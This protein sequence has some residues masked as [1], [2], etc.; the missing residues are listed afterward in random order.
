MMRILLRL[1]PLLAALM[2]ALTLPPA[3]LAGK[4]PE[5]GG[6]GSF[7]RSQILL[8]RLKSGERSTGQYL[9]QSQQEAKEMVKQLGKALKQ[10]EQAERAYAKSKGR[11]D[12]RFLLGPA[13]RIEQA[14][15]TARKLRE[16]LQ[17]A[18]G[19]LSQSITQT[20]AA[21]DR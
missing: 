20:L 11:P 4:P 8:I 7:K 3:T 1:A 6:T 5:P 21:N 16:E 9:K 13:V 19:E 12:D 2:A 15:Q 14:M 10:L 17:G 18:S